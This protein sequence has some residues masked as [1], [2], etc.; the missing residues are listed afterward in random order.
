M[1]PVNILNENRALKSADINI[2]IVNL[3]CKILIYLD[4]PVAPMAIIKYPLFKDHF[5]RISRNTE[6]ILM[7]IAA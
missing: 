6:A 3:Y 2:Y 1:S 5:L 4:K 7:T